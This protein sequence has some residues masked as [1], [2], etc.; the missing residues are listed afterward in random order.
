[1]PRFRGSRPPKFWKNSRPPNFSKKS[2]ATKILEKSTATK[3]YEKST[4][5]KFLEKSTATKIFEKSTA[6]KF[7]EK[8]TATKFFEKSTA[9]NIFEQRC[10]LQG[11]AGGGHQITQPIR[12]PVQL[13]SL[14]PPLPGVRDQ[15]RVFTV[16]RPDH[17]WAHPRPRAGSGLQIAGAPEPRLFLVWQ[18]EATITE[19]D[20]GEPL[21]EGPRFEQARLRVLQ[22]PLTGPEVGYELQRLL[23]PGVGQL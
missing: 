3:I 4:A 21:H 12:D 19:I 20:V 11:L 16:P 7:F 17:L 15:L 9:T 6:P 22:E 14:V 23:R 2:T 1:M 18:P 10:A 5:P 8:S 13:L